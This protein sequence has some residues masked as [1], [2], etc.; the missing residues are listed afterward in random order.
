[1]IDLCLP[2]LAFDLYYVTKLERSM[3]TML[4]NAPKKPIRAYASGPITDNYDPKTGWMVGGSAYRRP[5]QYNERNVYQTDLVS[6]DTNE[7]MHPS[8]RARMAL[9]K[10]WKPPALDG[11][12][13]DENGAE[14]ENTTNV[15]WRKD[16]ANGKVVELREWRMRKREWHDGE[17]SAEEMWMGPQLMD[18]LKL[19]P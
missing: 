3:T 2:Y 13:K 12:N 4:E 17:R 6:N 15:V 7:Y 11:F 5:G 16:V 9:L 14:T 1:M 19:R 18:T 8:V 10:D